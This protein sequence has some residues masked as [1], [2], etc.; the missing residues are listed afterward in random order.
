[1]PIVFARFEVTFE[2]MSATS[3]QMYAIR[4]AL[5]ELAE[6]LHPDYP[7]CHFSTDVEVEWTMHAGVPDDEE[8][9]PPPP[10][11]PK[12]TPSPITL[13]TEGIYALYE[14]LAANQLGVT[15]P[16]TK[17]LLMHLF[18]QTKEVYP[19]QMDAAFRR[20]ISNYQANEGIAP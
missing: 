3:A 20:G 19:E 13:P 9:C 15:E 8:T 16:H 18:E 1:M 2:H 10:P 7:E 17:R 12:D 14:R 11:D 4:Q 6:P 5:Q